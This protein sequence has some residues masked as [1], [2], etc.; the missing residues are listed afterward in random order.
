MPEGAGKGALP[1][2]KWPRPV[3]GAEQGMVSRELRRL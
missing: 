3:R 1:Y 2:F